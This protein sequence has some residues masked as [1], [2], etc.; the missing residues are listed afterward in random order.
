MEVRVEIHANCVI[1]S[2]FSNLRMHPHQKI[3]RE[4]ELVRFD[5]KRIFKRVIKIQ[6]STLIEL[7]NYDRTIL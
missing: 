7:S 5:I 4:V 3:K 1:R 2:F 6:K